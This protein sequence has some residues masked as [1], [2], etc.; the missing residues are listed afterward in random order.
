MSRPLILFD[1]PVE[2]YERIHTGYGDGIMLRPAIIANMKR[3]PERRHII[4]T[5]ADTAPI[6]KDIDNLEVV[7]IKESKALNHEKAN[8]YRLG[9]SLRLALKYDSVANFYALSSPCADYESERSPFDA[10]EKHRTKYFFERFDGYLPTL[11]P[12]LKSKDIVK[13]MAVP[14]GRSIIKSRQQIFCDVVGVPFTLGNYN[15]QFSM[16]EEQYANSI[17]GDVGDFVAVNLKASTP[18]RDYKYMDA[19]VDYTAAREN[20]V[21]I[22]DYDAEYRGKRSNVFLIGN[23]DIRK[24]W[25]VISRAKWFIGPDTFGVHAAGSTGV[26]TYGIFGPTDPKC[27]LTHYKHAAWNDKWKTRILRRGM[28]RGC[29][30]QYCWYKPCRFISCINLK[31]PGYYYHDAVKKLRLED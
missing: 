6:Y 3:Y 13:R 11:L 5:Y 4:H 22:T 7:T 24:A 19:L 10:R 25:A 12:R 29:G 17:V 14:T 23:K 26:S 15:V 21:C 20:A 30:R 8:V 18:V 1:E 28:R 27:R 31:P 2:L 16:E 9:V